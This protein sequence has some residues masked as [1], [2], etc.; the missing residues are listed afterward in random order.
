LLRCR[1][2]IRCHAAAAFIIEP[3]LPSLLRCRSLL[4]CAAADFIVALPLPS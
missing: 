3:P 1:F 2:C 4:C